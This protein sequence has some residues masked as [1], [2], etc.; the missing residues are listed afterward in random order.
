MPVRTRHEALHVLRQRLR[1][2]LLNPAGFW[3]KRGAGSVQ[4]RSDCQR[5]EMA[6]FAQPSCKR[7]ERNDAGASSA[8]TVS[9]Q[10]SRDQGAL[11]KTGS[12][13]GVT[14]G[15]RKNVSKAACLLFARGIRRLL[16]PELASGMRSVPSP[17]ACWHS[18][19]LQS[20]SKFATEQQHRKPFLPAG[21][22]SGRRLRTDDCG[23][24]DAEEASAA[25]LRSTPCE[26]LAAAMEEI[27]SIFASKGVCLP[28]KLRLEPPQS[29]VS[30]GGDFRHENRVLAKFRTKQN[31]ALFCTVLGKC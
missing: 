19:P 12:T 18:H 15:A 6:R 5:V 28:A 13:T 25:R 21:S 3:W 22:A 26:D 2:P 10:R 29:Q 9:P 4:R 16:C 20:H 30:I 11:L 27:P 1:L 17:P 31:L 23:W 24:G 14:G 8:T 7:L